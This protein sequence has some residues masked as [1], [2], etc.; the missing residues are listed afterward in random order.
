[1]PLHTFDVGLD[2]DGC[3]YDFYNAFITYATEHLDVEVPVDTQLDEPATPPAVWAFYQDWGWT[4]SHFLE[5][6]R[7]GIEDKFLFRHG[8]PLEGAI[9]GWRLLHESGHRIHVI[10]DRGLPGLEDI[11][12]ESTRLWLEEY[13]LP[14]DT[15]TFSPDKTRI[16]EFAK[17]PTRT[18]FIEDRA[19]NR[20]ALAAAGIAYPYLLTQPYNV[21]IADVPRVNNVLEFAQAVNI[22]AAR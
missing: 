7:R 19:D 6:F 14:Y 3:N 12:H 8:V 4:Y 13:D 18:A 17:D 22:H 20:D 11:A 9:E 5:M 15:L 10:T 2:L 1:M 16:L 21:D